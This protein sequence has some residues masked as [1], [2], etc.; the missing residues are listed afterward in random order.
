MRRQDFSNDSV[1]AGDVGAGKA[2][3]ALY[4]IVREG[5]PAALTE[6]LRYGTPVQASTSSEDAFLRIRYKTPGATASG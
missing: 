6:P 2:V 4:E 1:D 5:S 3:T